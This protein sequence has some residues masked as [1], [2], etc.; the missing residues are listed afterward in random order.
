M[1]L[2]YFCLFVIF[3]EHFLILFR[4]LIA[5]LIEDKDRF[6]EKRRLNNIHSQAHDA[7]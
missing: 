2:V 5:E 4:M 3:V 7:K 6:F 1:E